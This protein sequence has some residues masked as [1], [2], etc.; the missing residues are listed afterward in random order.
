METKANYFLIMAGAAHIMGILDAYW[1]HALIQIKI[2][3]QELALAAR[4]EF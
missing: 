3:D 1:E 4:I 2:Q